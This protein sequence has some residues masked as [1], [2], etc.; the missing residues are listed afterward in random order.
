M[1]NM[2]ICQVL[3]HTL[4]HSDYFPQGFSVTD[5]QIPKLPI[6]HMYLYV[7]S[8]LRYFLFLTRHVNLLCRR[9][10]PARTFSRVLTNFSHVRSDTC[11]MFDTRTR[12]FDFSGGR[13]SLRRLSHQS[14][15]MRTTDNLV[16][17][18]MY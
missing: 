13:S 8:F 10:K 12:T 9:R 15:R 7:Y 6:I 5:Y 11:S 2:T 18:L 16:S 4:R 1:D 3:K 17:T 14:H